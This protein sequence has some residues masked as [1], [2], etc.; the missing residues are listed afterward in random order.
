MRYGKKTN[1]PHGNF[2]DAFTALEDLGDLPMFDD[3]KL[4]KFYLRGARQ[5]YNRPTRKVSDERTNK[6]LFEAY[7]NA[8]ILTSFSRLMTCREEMGMCKRAKKP[9]LQAG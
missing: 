8:A 4:V 5:E 3:R 1:K 9:G 6:N 7:M 2:R